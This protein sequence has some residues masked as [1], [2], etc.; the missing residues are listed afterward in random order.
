[1]AT[2]SLNLKRSLSKGDSRVRRPENWRQHVP[3]PV[4]QPLGLQLSDPSLG[5]L[6]N[7]LQVPASIGLLVIAALCPQDASAM[8][9]LIPAASGPVSGILCL[10]KVS[11]L[12][13]CSAVT[14]ITNSSMYEPVLM[15]CPAQR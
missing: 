14:S 9:G 8:A 1:M 12:L 13:N 7:A 15:A 2:V 11:G 6:A 4:K 5:R 3:T 10:R